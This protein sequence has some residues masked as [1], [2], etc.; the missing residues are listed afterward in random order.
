MTSSP[1]LS[2]KLF[3]RDLAAYSD[4]E[5]DRYL[6]ES[7]RV[8]EVE[9]P[10]NLP[11]SFI[12]R[13]RDRAR[14]TSETVQSRP[15]ALDQVAAR[16]LQ[17]SASKEAPP[18]SSFPP[19]RPPVYE[20]EPYPEGLLA[21][22]SSP[23]TLP[24]TPD[25]ERYCKDLHGQT[26]AYHALVND[27]GRPSHPLSLLEDIVKSPGEYREILSFW[28]D[29]GKPDDWKVFMDQL[30]RWE[31]FRRLQ[32][33]ARGQSDY[34]HWRDDWEQGHRHLR[35]LG[36]T[37]VTF[38]G[39][40][41]D[42]EN[43]WQYIWRRK[44]E[45]YGDEQIVIVSGQ[46]RTW[47][48]FVGRQQPATREEGR[49]PMYV[50]AVKGR[51]TKHGFTRTFQLD[52]DPARQ[53][54]L[55]TWIEYLGYEYWWYDQ[56]ALSKRQQQRLDDAWKK[57]VDANVLRPFETE[58]FIC[59]IESGFME[60]SEEDRA[61]EAVES[62]ES[63]VMLTREAISDPRCVKRSPK[64]SR[65]R[66]LEAQSKL[67]AAE[68]DYDSVKRRHNLIYEFTE[69]TKNI[70]I[71]KRNAERH[72]ILLRWM[73]QQVP[74]IELELKQS[75]TT[76]NDSIRGRRR[77]LKLNRT[78]EP[79]KGQGPTDQN[80]DGRENP[81]ISDRRTRIASTSQGGAR[82]KRN[83]DAVDEE[84]LSKRPRHNGRNRGLSDRKTSDSVDTAATRNGSK[85]T[86]A[87]KAGGFSG[88]GSSLRSRKKSTLDAPQ[89]STATK[90]LRRSTRIAEREQRLYTAI[91]ASFD[92]VKRLHQRTPKPIQ[93]P[94]PPL[95]EPQEPKAQHSR[96]QQ[97]AQIEA[98]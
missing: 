22:N 55:T 43:D 78:D 2:P 69:R 40:S 17:V 31:D 1:P 35:L 89:P 61:K 72:S 80:S 76:G 68:K 50:K 13:L 79:S 60:Q 93:M 77:R 86:A 66:L 95:A 91:A 54:K 64:E 29:R 42:D 44:K 41:I 39:R 16:L 49:F 24:P 30:S 65:Q 3:A 26:E 84:R 52:E 18:R 6:E 90:P 94:T 8:V 7:G 57:L 85:T 53:D 63:A 20:G 62:A 47:E 34:D 15:V 97:R 19:T 21:T 98:A 14:R 38:A 4:A 10:E 5:L 37:N 36:Y 48:S 46:Y 67:D 32:K 74:L 23:S 51:L 96:R 87:M 71:A 81:T 11:E 56:Y 92:T 82:R 28:Q 9:D 70:R 33:F 27:G 25:E 59:S 12:Q 45:N 75:N 73:L 58:E 83:H 88:P